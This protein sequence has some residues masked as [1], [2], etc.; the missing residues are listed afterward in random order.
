MHQ[1]NQPCTKNNYNMNITQEIATGE[2]SV[3]E[4]KKELPATHE[5]YLKT[6]VAFANGKGGRII[7]GVEDQ[8]CAVVGVQVESVAR[9][10]DRISNAIVDGIV[11]QIIPD[12]YLENVDDKILIV[13][14]IPPGQHTPY[15]IR[16]QGPENGV[17]LRAGATTRRAENLQRFELVLKGGNMNYDSYV[18]RSLAPAST[19]EINKLCRDITELGHTAAPVTVNQLISWGGLKEV[20]GKLMPTVTFCLFARPFAE[21]FCRIQCAEF[22]GNDKVHFLDNRE[23]DMPVHEMITEA[24]EY[25]MRRI[26]TAYRI[27]GIYREELPE[28]PRPALREIIVNAILH[29]NYLVPTYIQI[30]IYDNRI[31][32]YTPGGLPGHLTKEQLLQGSCSRLRNPLLADV[33]HR[34]K[35]VEKWGSGI[36]RI[37]DAF[38]EAGLPLPEYRVDETSVTVV[39]PREYSHETG[40]RLFSRNAE[41][42]LEVREEYEPAPNLFPESRKCRSSAS[43]EDVWSYIRQR[44]NVTF[45]QMLADL[46]IGRRTLAYRLEELKSRGLIVRTGNTRSAVWNAAPRH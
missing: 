28:I 19:D 9:T 36:K 26:R 46:D 18:D 1:N 39:V 35:I 20:E 7:F 4:F 3:L 34:M 38:R 22:K 16:K 30:A 23:L 33:F 13:V 41:D 40:K 24:E 21:R 12:I 14:D 15:Y 5:Q 43:F 17:Y 29:R 37:F 42:S 2:S 27:E 10:L 11:P 25:V 32:F 44:K 6:V 31:E 8:T 45:S